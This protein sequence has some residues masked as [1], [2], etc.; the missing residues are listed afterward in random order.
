MVAR[1]NITNSQPTGLGA[2]RVC[3]FYDGSQ[4]RET[5]TRYQPGQEYSVELAD[6]SMPLKQGRIHLDVAPLDSQ[7]SRVSVRFEFVPKFGVLGWLMA[8][9]M[10]LKLKQVSSKLVQGL[11]DH[12]RTGRV[13][14][15][16]GVLLD[17]SDI[18]TTGNVDAR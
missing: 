8:P 1:S 16:N 18:S 10:K 15:E 3:Y 12:L 5:I 13:V 4:V 7:R 11:A 6:I 17:A 14:G 9:L 2:E